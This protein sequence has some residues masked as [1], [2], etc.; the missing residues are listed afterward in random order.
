MARPNGHDEDPRVTDLRRYKAQREKA[1]RKPPAKPKPS[2]GGGVLGSNPRAKLIL[3][4]AALAIVVF[5]VLPAV[6]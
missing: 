6:L 2:L 4:L 1:A 3:A 5:L